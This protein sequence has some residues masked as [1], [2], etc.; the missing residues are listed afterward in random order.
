M[1]RP[2]AGGAAGR[3]P[4]WSLRVIRGW[5][6]D[7]PAEPDLVG[8]ML[9]ELE[10]PAVREAI[11]GHLRQAGGERGRFPVALAATEAG[12]WMPLVLLWLVAG[13]WA[14][15]AWLAVLVPAEVF[16]WRRTLRQ[17]MHPPL[18]ALLRGHGIDAC[19]DC[20][21]LG[22][23]EA[24]AAPCGRCGCEHDAVPLGWLDD[25]GAE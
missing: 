24:P 5:P 25:A 10:R 22:P 15:A 13:P 4:G 20:G 12:L 23:G 18:R 8:S 6:A 2:A 11:A 21:A 17:W 7:L 9:E 16:I 14:A 19:L 1:T 3:G